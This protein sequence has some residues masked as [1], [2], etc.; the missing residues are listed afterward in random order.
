LPVAGDVKVLCLVRTPTTMFLGAKTYLSTCFSTG[1]GNGNSKIWLYTG[2]CQGY[3]PL[4]LTRLTRE[5]AAAAMD[6]RDIGKIIA[7]I[8]LSKVVCN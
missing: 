2:D 5:A 8:K 6:L 7:Q 3:C 1:K 4:A